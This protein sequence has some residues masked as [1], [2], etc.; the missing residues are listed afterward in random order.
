MLNDYI[1]DVDDSKK[2]LEEANKNLEQFYLRT[3]GVKTQEELI[4]EVNTFIDNNDLPTE[5]KDSLMEV[6]ASINEN[7]VLYRKLMD[8]ENI[9][10]KYQEEKEKS[11]HEKEEEVNDIKMDA[12]N[13]VKTSLNDVGIKTEN[14][15]ASVE[16]I[17]EERDIYKLKENTDNVVDYYKSRDVDDTVILSSKD[18]TKTFDNTKDDTLLNE[19]VS[20][21]TKKNKSY[22][23][24]VTVHDNSIELLNDI[25][26]PNAINF[27]AMMVLVLMTDVNSLD[28]YNMKLVKDKDQNMYKVSFVNRQN[29]SSDDSIM[30]QKVSTTIN[31]YDSNQSYLDTLSTKAEGISLSFQI[32]QDHVLNKNGSFKFAVKNNNGSHIMKFGFDDN[33]QNI[34]AAFIENHIYLTTDDKNN[35]ILIINSGDKN[36]LFELEQVSERLQVKEEDNQVVKMQ[37]ANYQKVKTYQSNINNNAANVSQTFLITI[38]IADILLV[39]LG[40]YFIFS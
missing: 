7:T 34:V 18:I 27:T 33:Y 8:L 21:E 38:L 10:R 1:K 40:M 6:I 5:V 9:M 14:L 11:Y 22:N 3:T 12:L 17:N 2:E 28:E 20:Q 31:N 36:Q 24:N 35:S 19:V 26:D 13:H 32:I 39:F 23:P 30:Y 4:K 15:S 37:E 29:K 25:N 16:S